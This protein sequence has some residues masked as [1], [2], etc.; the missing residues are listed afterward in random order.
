ME[1]SDSV[2]SEFQR[3]FNVHTP[4]VDDLSKDA[5]QVTERHVLQFVKGDGVLSNGNVRLSEENV[6]SF[7][8]GCHSLSDSIGVKDVPVDVIVNKEMMGCG[9]E[10]RQLMLST[11]LCAAV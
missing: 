2:G 6:D 8:A 10:I 4:H 11:F 1:E 9:S 3:C 7:N 5:G